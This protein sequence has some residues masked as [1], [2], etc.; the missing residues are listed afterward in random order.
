M[1]PEP[2]SLSSMRDLS[3]SALCCPVGFT[4]CARCKPPSMPMC[5]V[6]ESSSDRARRLETD[7]R[8]CTN[9]RC[10]GAACPME[11]LGGKPG[12]TSAGPRL[13]LAPM[14]SSKNWSKSHDPSCECPFAIYSTWYAP[15][16]G[17]EACCF[18]ERPG[19]AVGARLPVG[20]VSVHCSLPLALDCIAL[21]VGAAWCG[22]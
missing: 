18:R 12:L 17:L 21:G 2:R 16:R 13:C 5:S 20:N 9:L 19:P 10:E 11:L 6:S 15:H 4:D 14:N 3:A 8:D 22:T 1:P 7:D